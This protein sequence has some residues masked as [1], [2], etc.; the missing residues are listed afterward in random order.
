[1]TISDKYLSN[2]TYRHNW[3][4]N[5]DSIPITDR[6]KQIIKNALNIIF[7]LNKK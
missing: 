7:F 3:F 6:L 2:M 4:L 1:M 5:I